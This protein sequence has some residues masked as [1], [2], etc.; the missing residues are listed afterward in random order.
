MIVSQ[1]HRQP[2]MCATKSR[3]HVIW[4]T[5]TPS[6]RRRRRARHPPTAAA[7]ASQRRHRAPPQPQPRR[8]RNDDTRSGS[9]TT[10]TRATL[11]V[12]ALGPPGPRVSS[13]Q[14]SRSAGRAAAPHSLGSAI[15]SNRP[16]A[17][18]G[19]LHHESNAAVVFR[20][21]ASVAHWV[22]RSVA[23]RWGSVGRRRDGVAPR[24]HGPPRRAIVFLC[25]PSASESS[26][27]DLALSRARA[28]WIV[29]PFRA[30]LAVL[31][32]GR[33]PPSPSLSFARSRALAVNRLRVRLLLD[34]SPSLPLAR[35]LALLDANES[36]SLTFSHILSNF[37]TLKTA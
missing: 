7:R 18:G 3:K 28:M 33:S 35:L 13:D 24:C 31:R 10:T 4:Q 34:V 11:R 12:G 1:C 16:D 32:Q 5:R 6:A 2:R 37:L 15:S 27:L 8:D 22:Y 30:R 19:S 36:Y 25:L 29:R 9:H 23:G 14:G 26:S 17:H 20:A 21:T